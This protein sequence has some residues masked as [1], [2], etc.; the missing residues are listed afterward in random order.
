MI[1]HIC[2]DSG[3]SRKVLRMQQNRGVRARRRKWER[4]AVCPSSLVVVVVVMSV[5]VPYSAMSSA[6]VSVSMCVLS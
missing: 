1:I 4:G 6:R 5:S 3:F 2:V